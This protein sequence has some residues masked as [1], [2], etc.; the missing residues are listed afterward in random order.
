MSRPASAPGSGT[1]RYDPACTVVL[2]QAG[3]SVALRA[4]SPAVLRDV[5]ESLYSYQER[6]AGTPACWQVEVACD[7]AV[8][9]PGRPGRPGL[10]VGPQI[11]ACPRDAG[12]PGLAFWVPELATLIAADP[13]RRIVRARCAGEDAARHWALSLTRQA[14]TSQLL[15]AGLI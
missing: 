5:R 4:S 15:A 13:G 12:G 1:V 14:M 7:P 9:D 11:T 8:T 2:T 3:A 6:P 10:D